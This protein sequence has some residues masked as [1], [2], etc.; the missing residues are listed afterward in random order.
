MS[1]NDRQIGGEHYKKH[2]KT[3]EEHW[4]RQWRLYG[5]GYFIGCITKYV[6]R[7]ADKNGLQD[8]EKA[9]HFLDKLIELETASPSFRPK[10]QAAELKPAPSG[11]STA[12][13]P[14]FGW[15][16]P[17]CGGVLRSHEP[18]IHLMSKSFFCPECKQQQAAPARPY[19]LTG[20]DAKVPTDVVGLPV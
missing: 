11:V 8:L 10:L 9:R 15:H 2:G 18:L 17:R 16:C 7:Y 20:V 4:D 19:C 13:A 6:E 5:P 1:A 3:G 14:Y 12:D